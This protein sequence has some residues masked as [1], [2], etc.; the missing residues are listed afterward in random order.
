MT[1]IPLK[2][3][4]RVEP[5]NLYLKIYIFRANL[6]TLIPYYILLDGFGTLLHGGSALKIYR[7]N[8][9]IFIKISHWSDSNPPLDD[10][11]GRGL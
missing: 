7:W 3:K 11:V 10:P 1:L 9:Q 4:I 2:K 5:T 6:M 8:K